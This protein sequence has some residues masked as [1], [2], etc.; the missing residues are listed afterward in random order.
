MTT[1]SRPELARRGPI[2]L[3]PQNDQN[4][5]TAR[6]LLPE[7]A[8]SGLPV[9]ILL[10]D[11]VFKQGLD[12]TGFPPDVRVRSLDL[13]LAR[14][15]YRLGPLRQLAAVLRAVRPMRRVIGRPAVIVAFNDGALQRLAFRVGRGARTVLVIDGMISD[16]AEPAGLAHRVRLALKRVG[17][18]VRSTPLGIVMPSE[19]GLSAVDVVFVVGEHSAAL[20]RRSGA[21]SGR[22]VASGLPRWPHAD[23]GD[24]PTRVRRV[25]YLTA[26]FAWHNRHAAD[27]AQARDVDIISQ[28]CRDLG[29]ELTVRVHPRDTVSRWQGRG[30]TIA[31]SQDEP[32]EESIRRADLVLAMVSTGLLEAISLGRIARSVIISDAFDG[33]VDSFVADPFLGAIR[34]RSEL[35]DVLVTYG[36]GVAASD[37]DLQQHGLRPYVAASGPA[38]ARAI[39]SVILEAA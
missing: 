26:S 14:P 2:L 11:G 32:V 25:L 38:A 19:V 16:Y 15:F 17:H 35:H 33:Y 4:L 22:I 30:L 28:V 36:E 34:T 31:T 29:L 5:E 7:L 23:T 37:Y 24:R 21:R 6:I 3:L 9:S 27:E 13:E 8:S 10:M 12:G 39:A 20:L 1:E 18:A